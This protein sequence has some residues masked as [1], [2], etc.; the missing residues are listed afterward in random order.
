MNN[1]TSWPTAFLILGLLIVVGAVIMTLIW[2]VSLAWR[3]RS[4]AA[5]VREYQ[6]LTTRVTAGQEAISTELAALR[7]RIGSIEELLRQ[8]D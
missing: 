4:S 5:A 1:E 6:E 2:Q 7:S 8:V 3:A